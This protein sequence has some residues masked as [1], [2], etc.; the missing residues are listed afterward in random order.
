MPGS[1][2]GVVISHAT[3]PETNHPAADPADAA[4]L[5]PGLLL[6][7]ATAA[8][9][10]WANSP[11]HASY[12]TAWHGWRH[13]A[14]NDG[15]MSVFFFVVGLEVRRE[16]TRGELRDRAHATVPVVAAIGGMAVPAL[17]YLALAPAGSRHG[18]GI[19]MATDIAFALTVLNLAAS[20][21]APSAM[22]AFLLTLAVVDDIG[23]VAVIAVAYHPPGL[24]VHPTLIAVVAG[25]AM[26][27]ALSGKLERALTP[28]TGLVVLPAFA[29]A[30]AGVRLA[31]TSMSRVTL[32]V[33]AGLV[34]GKPIGAVAGAAFAAHERTPGRLT[35]ALAAEHVA[36]VGLTAGIGFTVS[37]FIAD[38]AFDD[39]ATRAA[40]K[41][42][43]LLG[44]AAAGV[45]A[46]VF[47]RRRF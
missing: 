26:P 47:M 46:A 13:T 35:P 9:L 29:L 36:A 44:S 32:A 15:L 20:R 11:W 4:D 40:A 12:E 16:L 7:A 24:P 30:N 25:L 22:R 33:A 1:L 45:L 34:V 41:L 28:W 39:G 18:W 27:A 23:A 2:V 21:R 8:A 5:R 43:V 6:L 38:L 37:L 3:M 31:E 10:V 19:P 14:V 42:G 17:L